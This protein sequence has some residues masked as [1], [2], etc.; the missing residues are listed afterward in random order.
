M[1]RLNYNG[2][3]ATI[4]VDVESGL[5]CGRVVGIPDV[6]G[7]QGET[8]AKAEADFHSAIDFFLEDYNKTGKTPPKPFSGNVQFRVSPS[9]H[10]IAYEIAEAKGISFNSY[11]AS[12]LMEAVL[13]ERPD[14]EAELKAEPKRKYRKVA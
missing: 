3:T 4:E 8:I 6:I 12:I 10:S 14:A 1:S 13:K 2:Y 11:G 5:L 9:L 7:F